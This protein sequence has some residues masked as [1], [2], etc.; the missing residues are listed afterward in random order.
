MTR[1]V[2]AAAFLV[3][4]LP[5]HAY[6]PYRRLAAA[7]YNRQIGCELCHTAQ[8]STERNDFGNAWRA[9]GENNDAFSALANMDFDHDGAPTADEIR[10]GS[11]PS[12]PKSTPASPGRYASHARDTFVPREQLQVV[13]DA[14]ER[15][16][17]VEPTLTSEQLAALKTAL[18]REPSV[19]ERLPTIYLA[20]RN[21]KADEA[22]MFGHSG[23]G[24]RTI[25]LVAAI[26]T[27]GMIRRTALYRVGSDTGAAYQSYM[28][29]FTNRTLATVPKSGVI[30]CP[31]ASG[32]ATYQSAITT[33][34]HDILASMSVTFGGRG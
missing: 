2:L 3:A 16:D 4:A 8:G 13:L 7:Y 18:G 34:I 22:V 19:S 5:A 10:D 9:K 32:A 11:N 33:A 6:P 29:C 17:A 24:N 30:G 25:S 14:A 31:G 23:T 27:D 1:L 26:G 28:Q 15:I 12:D 20:I 21:G